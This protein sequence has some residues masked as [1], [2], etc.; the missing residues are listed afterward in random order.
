MLKKVANWLKGR[1]ILALCISSL[2][3]V[4]AV[5]GEP[6]NCP[7]PQLRQEVE[8]AIDRVV[9]AHGSSD[10]SGVLID[11]DSPRYCY[12]SSHA[13]GYRSTNKKIPLAPTDS[14][15]TASITKLF[16]ASTILRLVEQGKFSLD[17]PVEGLLPGNVVEALKK[18]GV[19]PQR[20]T[21]RHLLSHTAGLPDH[22]M[23]KRYF[24][25]ILTQPSR[26]WTPVEQVAL[27]H[28]YQL[29][30]L[31]LGKQFAYSDTGYILLGQIIEKSTGL[32][33]GEAISH[34]L[35]FNKLP[36]QHLAMEDS[37]Y[38]ESDR[39]PRA[40]QYLGALDTYSWNPSID[41][42][43]GGGLVATAQDLA[44]FI[45]ALFA[46]E[47]FATP[48]SLE[49]MLSFQE[50]SYEDG[51]G[52]GIFRVDFD[53][54]WALGHTGFW[55]TFVFYLPEYD[56]TIAGS[57]M[58]TEGVKGTDLAKAAFSSFEVLSQQK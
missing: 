16:T 56:L 57:V 30:W 48:D 51:Y 52:M 26:R 33:L 47:I 27:I 34:Y 22:A 53:G 18:G 46:Q 49:H 55:N 23:D 21:V 39:F 19:D 9:V 54:Y 6:A 44:T 7:D 43:G 41:L 15:R 38:Q 20:I 17:S 45:R 3:G 2:V 50:N 32:P 11:I 12:H 1:V 13:V 28:E 40:H 29:K 35:Q 8:S 36:L 58:Q 31:P 25:A 10:G 4:Q 42:H 24:K 5:A 37:S 14:F